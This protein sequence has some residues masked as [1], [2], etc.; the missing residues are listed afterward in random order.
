MAGLLP[1]YW[2]RRRCDSRICALDDGSPGPGRRLA[3]SAVPTWRAPMA[4]QRSHRRTTTH[5]PQYLAKRGVC[6][7]SSAFAHHRTQE[8][9]MPY[10]FAFA[11]TI[12]VPRK[13]ELPRDLPETA[14][15][16]TVTK[17]EPDSARW[18]RPHCY[19]TLLNVD[20]MAPVCYRGD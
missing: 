17:P 16:P 15:L 18:P 7:A 6:E 12:S 8:S 11:Q 3:S 19:S 14:D 2:P 13:S 4:T 20:Y 9:K 5:K 10:D 1:I